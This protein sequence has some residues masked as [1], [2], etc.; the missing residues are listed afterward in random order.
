PVAG[1]LVEALAESD[2]LEAAN[3]VIERLRL[4]ASDQQHPWAL[5]TVKRSTAVVSLARGHDDAAAADLAEA[6]AAYRSLGLE[7]ENARTLLLLG[8]VQRRFRKR[9]AAREALE[10]ARSAFEELCCVGWAQVA[11]GELTRVSGRR[12]ASEGDLT[13][14]E[15]RIAELVATGLS[16]K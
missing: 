16:N 1:D 2:R 14:T 11:D 4:L 7:F 12:K 15:R 5:A 13:P 9:T 8:R 3:E 6:A 10:Q